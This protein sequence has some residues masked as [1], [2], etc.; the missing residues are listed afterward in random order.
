MDITFEILGAILRVILLI[1]CIFAIIKV[2]KVAY[3]FGFRIFTEG[4][5][6]EEPGRDVMVSVD[7]GEGLTDIAKKL[8]DKGLTSDW[9]L[10]FVQAKLSEY[11]GKVEPGVYTLNTSYNT[12][13]LMAVL[14]KA[15]GEEAEESGDIAPAA[16]ELNNEAVPQTGDTV[17]AGSELVEGDLGEGEV[18]YAGEGDEDNSEIDIQ[19]G[20]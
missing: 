13:A 15:E 3:D 7:A 5:M 2:G 4:A 14:T 17:E 11:K 6:A 16:D 8:E 12:D 19:I 1:V 9:K 20:E 10:F 18:P